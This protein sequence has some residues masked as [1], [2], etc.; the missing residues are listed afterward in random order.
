MQ[1]QIVLHTT[2]HVY[3]PLIIY[4][5]ST[6]VQE[7][8]TPYPTKEHKSL[9]RHSGGTNSSSTTSRNADMPF[10]F[11]SSTD[12]IK[13]NVKS[14]NGSV[15]VISEMLAKAEK[16]ESN[17]GLPSPVIDGKVPENTKKLLLSVISWSKS[18][19]IFTQLPVED[20]IKLIKE[21][22]MEVNTLK[23]I[24]HIT[25]GSG[26]AFND[27]AQIENPAVASSIQK[28]TKECTV[29]MQDV[30]LDETELSCL[31]LIALMNPCEYMV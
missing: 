6:A 20:Q 5:F 9:P 2:V 29:K 15:S 21:S 12:M 22:W 3:I 1:V 31:K 14:Q 8:R 28:L 17:P 23:L 11:V 25:T 7:E 16:T 30:C 13:T 27:L 24:Y 18:I 4:I 26:V 10:P 19:P